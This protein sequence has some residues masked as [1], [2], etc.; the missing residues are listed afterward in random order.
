MKD[1]EKMYKLSRRENHLIQAK[2]SQ[3]EITFALGIEVQLNPDKGSL[4]MLI[5]D[6]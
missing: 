4:V 5:A 6:P 2:L 3:T 1:Y